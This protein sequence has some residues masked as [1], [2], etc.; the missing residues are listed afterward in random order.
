MGSP[1]DPSLTKVFLCHFEEQLIFDWSIDYKPISY[2]KYIDNS[3]LSFLSELQVTKIS[4]YMN[5]K[6]RTIFFTV[7]REENNSL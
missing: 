5:S 4:R 7:E 1:L 6:H 2:K 3:F